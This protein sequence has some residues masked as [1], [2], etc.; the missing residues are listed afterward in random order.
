[1]SGMDESDFIDSPGQQAAADQRFEETL[2]QLKAAFLNPNGS[3]AV[4]ILNT[5]LESGD[6]SDDDMIVEH[7]K[8]GKIHPIAGALFWALLIHKVFLGS[9]RW[10]ELM[11]RRME[12]YRGE[13][14]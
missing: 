10:A 13:D 11:G 8:I 1:M 9:D 2:D 3:F 6:H 12:G 7:V 5:D 4:Y 14:D